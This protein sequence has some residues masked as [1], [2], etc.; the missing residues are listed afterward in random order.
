MGTIGIL[1]YTAIYLFIGIWICSKRNWYS[2]WG[3]DNA[4]PLTAALC[5]MPI[6]LMI[7]FIKEFLNREWK[8]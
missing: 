5:F 7:V 8:N 1:G 6:N 3:N 4:V 2:D